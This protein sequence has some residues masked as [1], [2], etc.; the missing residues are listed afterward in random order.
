MKN[1][2]LTGFVPFQ[3][4]S[5]N[6]SQILVEELGRQ[7]S[8]PYL[9]LPVSYRRAPHILREKLL[10]QGSID[11]VLMFGQSGG[12]R[13]VSLERILLNLEDAE[14]ADEDG[15]R[16]Q[17]RS[18]S[19]HEELAKE[20]RLPLQNWRDELVKKGHAVEVSNYAG[21]FVCNSLAY[22]TLKLFSGL[23]VHV[24][25]LPE[26]QSEK[27]GNHPGMPIEAQVSTARDLI[28]LIQ[29]Q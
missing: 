12:R 27:F 23:F 17:H 20:I 28:Q 25:H 13:K 29:N 9:I 15:D 22:Q 18:I 7:L 26:Q 4:E 5:V 6:P 3:G 8:L 14:V 16:A 24:P 21:T 1:L 11:F 10:K 19:N 2:F